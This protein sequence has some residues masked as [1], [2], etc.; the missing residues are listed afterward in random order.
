MPGPNV[1]IEYCGGWGYAPR[2]TS[3]KQQIEN[4]VPSASVYMQKG[5]TGSFEVT[6]DGVLLFSKLQVGRFPLAQAV[7]A[8]VISMALG[9][10][11]EYVKQYEEEH[12]CLVLWLDSG[13]VIT[14]GFPDEALVENPWKRHPPELMFSRNSDNPL[15]QAG[16]TRSFLLLSRLLSYHPPYLGN[17]TF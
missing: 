9:H 3:L 15:L 11:P 13:H 8:Q 2:A 12:S 1:F 7:V 10:K 17:T 16:L 14:S 5:R 4:A 6:V